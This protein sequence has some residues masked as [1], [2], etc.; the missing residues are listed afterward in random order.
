MADDVFV[1]IRDTWKDLGTGFFDVHVALF[2]FYGERLEEHDYQT[3]TYKDAVKMIRAKWM[4][5][6][7]RE[8][9]KRGILLPR[10][11]DD[12]PPKLPGF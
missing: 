4:A 8:E 9:I 10:K 12:A 11:G 3:I 2:D 7:R 6:R 1:D 5:C